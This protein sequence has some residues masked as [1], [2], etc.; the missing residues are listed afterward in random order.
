MRSV[1][2]IAALLWNLF[3]INCAFAQS[4]ASPGM[5]AKEQAAQR[6]S[7]DWQ[8]SESI[9]SRV[10]AGDKQALAELAGMDPVVAVPVLANF[11]KDRFTDAERS[12]IAQSALKRVRGLRDYFRP[13][14]A[15]LHTQFGGDFDT[16]DEFETLALIGTKEAIA[17]AAPFLFDNSNFKN[18]EPNS[19]VSV[20]SL[21]YQAVFAL[22][23]M[24]LADAP[25]KK[26]FYKANDEDIQKWRE[27]WTV[28]KAEYE[29]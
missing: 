25:T 4:F 19:D 2:L 21:R 15:Y 23:K 17:A 20:S 1:T 24:D 5:A 3:S 13:R 6:A 9:K 10:Y 11:A 29:N 16:E 8:A 22:L 28:H 26:P 27:W 14:I 18:P 7:T 12:A